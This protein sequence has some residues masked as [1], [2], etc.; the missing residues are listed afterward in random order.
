MGYPGVEISI[1]AYFGRT[2]FKVAIDIGFGD[3]VEPI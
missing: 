3:I 2:R 1:M